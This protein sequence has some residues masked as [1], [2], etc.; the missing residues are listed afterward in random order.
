MR[1]GQ[2]ARCDGH[3]KLDMKG[4]KLVRTSSAR[5]AHVLYIFITTAASLRIEQGGGLGALRCAA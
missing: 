4:R 1:E 2:Q 3:E 5:E